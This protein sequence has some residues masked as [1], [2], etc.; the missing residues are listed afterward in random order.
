MHHGKK[1]LPLKTPFA[2][3]VRHAWNKNFQR[4]ICTVPNEAALNLV[5]GI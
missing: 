3:M 1:N 2:F 5:R 4:K